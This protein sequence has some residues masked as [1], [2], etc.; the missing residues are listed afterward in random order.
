[1]PEHDDALDTPAELRIGQQPPV[2]VDEVAAEPRSADDLGD[3][4]PA[5]EVGEG[6]GIRSGVGAGDHD[7]ARPALEDV[8]QVIGFARQVGFADAAAALVQR[9][10]CLLLGRLVR[11]GGIGI[12]LGDGRQLGGRHARASA[13][14]SPP[15]GSR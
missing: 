4:R 7:R 2:A 13:G 12:H 6:L 15:S 14:R 9:S 3:E 11:R 5:P 8:R 1:M 10:G